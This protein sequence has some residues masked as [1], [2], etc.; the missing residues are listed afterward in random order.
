[1]Y[2]SYVFD[3]KKIYYLWNLDFQIGNDCFHWIKPK[4]RVIYEIRIP[5]QLF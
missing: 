3:D 1:M 5:E 2:L 4:F